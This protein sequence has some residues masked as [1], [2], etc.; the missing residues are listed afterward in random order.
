MRVEL[1]GKPAEE[2]GRQYN[3]AKNPKLPKVVFHWSREG[4]GIR[5]YVIHINVLIIK[6]NITANGRLNL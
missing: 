6:S 2:E 5:P 1:Y 3:S 4:V